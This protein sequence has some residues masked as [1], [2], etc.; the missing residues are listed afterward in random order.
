VVL[1]LVAM[2]LAF[3]GVAATY[4]A[5][6]GGANVFKNFGD[7]FGAAATTLTAT[8]EQ[9][10]SKS[11]LGSFMMPGG[12]S[13]GTALPANATYRCGPRMGAGRGG[14]GQLIEVSEEFKTNVVNIAKNDEDVQKLLSE[15]YNVT[16]VRPIISSI[17]AGNGDVTTKATE[18]VVMLQKDTTGRAVVWIDVEEGKVTRIVIETRTVIEKA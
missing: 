17:V 8:G 10:A 7:V 1:S 15:G 13:E 11:A 4:A 2:V 5:A 3:G 14:P 9:A 18:A 12:F 16:D 6:A